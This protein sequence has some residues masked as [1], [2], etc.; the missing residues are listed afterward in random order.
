MVARWISGVVL[1]FMLVVPAPARAGEKQA[2][3]A[4]VVR[5]R[6]LDTIFEHFKLLAALAGQ[7]EIG[8]QIEGLIKTKVGP[9]GLEGIDPKRPFGAYAR[10]GKELDDVAGV[11]LVPIADE[12]AFLALLENL[13]FK[14]TK[15]PNDV[16]TIPAG[17]KDIKIDVYFRF[18]NKYAYV[19]ALKEDALAP[20]NL[21]H[22][23]KIFPA[24][25]TAALS[26]TVLIDQIPNTAKLVAMAFLEDKLDEIKDQKQ[27]NETKAQHALRAESLKD[28][29]RRAKNF[30][31]GGAELSAELDINRQTNELTAGFTLTGIPKSELANN[32]AELGK[33]KSLFGG[34]KTKDAAVHGLVHASL[35][36]AV[37]KAF[38]RVV[39]EELSKSLQNINDPAKRK[40]AERLIKALSPTIKAGEL[41]AAANLAGPGKDKHY[42]LVAGIK[43]VEGDNL[44]ATVRELLTETLQEL[45]AQAR[46]LIKL[47]ADSV[48]KVKIHRLEVQHFFDDKTRD[49]FG[50]HPV[51]VAFRNDALF[52]AVG[53]NGL[54]AIKSAV[55]STAQ[56]SSPV[57]VEIAVARLAP[58]FAKSEDQKQALEKAFGKGDEGK[59]RITLEGGMSLRGQ[60]STRLSVLQLL[61]QFGMRLKEK[62]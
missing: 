51:L 17:T 26:A 5:V 27:P 10:F 2:P 28:M 52:L 53:E 39:D 9:K 50:E 16:Y 6:S 43:L 55:S 54:A 7:E 13:N 48:G 44:A 62:L 32:I 20:A 21:V 60:L 33:L 35:P 23:A 29:A 47:D 3:P 4:V 45:P 57:H 41:D 19:T 22:P 42:T 30:L 8:N 18:A 24:N 1:A 46:E 31:E 34:L 11:A 14:A 37:K 12:K 49:V 38:E 58:L 59:I 40:Q 25:Q 36:D 56:S 15:R 61:G